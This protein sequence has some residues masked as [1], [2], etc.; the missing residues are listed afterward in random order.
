MLEQER[1]RT[2]SDQSGQ[3]LTPLE[4]RQALLAEIEASRQAIAEFSDEELEVIVGGMSDNAKW[5]IG[6]GVGAPTLAAASFLGGR[7]AGVKA[8]Q[9]ALQG[10][11][12]GLVRITSQA[13]H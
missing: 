10:A 8:A 9:K 11:D 1:K 13:S 12:S 4:L 3:S 2:M 6:V 5:G 7:A